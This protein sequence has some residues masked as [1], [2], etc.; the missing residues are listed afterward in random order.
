MNNKLITVVKEALSCGLGSISVG[1][2]T[3]DYKIKIDGEK[4]PLIQIQPGAFVWVKEPELSP[5][6][7]FITG[8]L[9]NLEREFSQMMVLSIYHR[10]AEKLEE[11]F[12]LVTGILTLE[13]KPIIKAAGTEDY[14]SSLYKKVLYTSFHLEQAE[15]VFEENYSS[16]KLT[17]KARGRLN[18][19]KSISGDF[20]EPGIIKENKVIVKIADDKNIN[21]S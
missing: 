3:S 8:G 20:K 18:M 9:K 1:S 7:P 21:Q 5:A 12:T 4:F 14:T 19:A 13:E 6:G 10:E 2:I 16:Y 15:P 17:F 11:L